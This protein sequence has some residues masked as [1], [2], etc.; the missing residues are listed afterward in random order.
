MV[1]W[2]RPSAL[3]RSSGSVLDGRTLNHQ[4]SWRDGQAVEVVDRD[5]VAVGVR[6]LDGGRDAGLVGDGRS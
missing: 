2:S 3:S 1:A 6:R 5:A 4:S